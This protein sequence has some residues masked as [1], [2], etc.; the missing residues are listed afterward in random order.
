M[1]NDL[2]VATGRRIKTEIDA[3]WHPPA[4]YAHLHKGGHIAALHKHIKNKIFMRADISHFFSCINRSRVSRNLKNLFCSYERAREIAHESTVRNPSN[5]AEYIIPYGF[6][7]SPVIASLC[8]YKSRLGKYLH[9]INKD[10]FVVTV[11][12]DDILISTNLPLASAE[13][14]FSTLKAK[15]EQANFPLNSEKTVG[16]SQDATAFNIIIKKDSLKILQTRLQQFKSKIL[17]TDNPNEIVGVLR[18]VEQIDPN[19]ANILR[20]EIEKKIQTGATA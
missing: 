1:P 7:Q 20:H 15:A 5:P 4:Y 8:L 9:G 18:Y 3:V 19:Q 14:V 13:T 10:G 6:I 12:M 17:S 11:Y 16:P 2:S